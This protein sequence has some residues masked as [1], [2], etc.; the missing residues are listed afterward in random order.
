MQSLNISYHKIE[1]LPAFLIIF[2]TITC[3]TTSSVPTRET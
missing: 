2:F 3:L 1:K